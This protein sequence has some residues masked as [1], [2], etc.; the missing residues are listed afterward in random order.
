MYIKKFELLGCAIGIVTVLLLCFWPVTTFDYVWD[1]QFIYS[2]FSGMPMWDAVSHAFT[3]AFLKENYYRPVSFA[4]WLTALNFD[5]SAFILHLINLT[6]HILNSLLIYVIVFR[7]AVNYADSIYRSLIAA[8]AALFYGLSPALAQSVAWVSA[9]FDLQVTFFLLLAVALDGIINSLKLRIIAVALCFLLATLCKEMAATFVIILISLHLLIDKLN[10][11]SLNQE[12]FFREGRLAV[13][14]GILCTGFIYLIIRYANLKYLHV[15]STEDSVAIT[16]KLIISGKILFCYL[17]LIVGPFFNYSPLH[18]IENSVTS[19]DLAAMMGLLFFLV[20]IG[21]LWTKMQDIGLVL[22]AFNFSL[23]PVLNLLG[24][25]GELNPVADRYLTLPLAILT[26]GLALLLS[27]YLIYFNRFKQFVLSI[28]VLTWLSASVFFGRDAINIWRN[29]IAL[30]SYTVTVLPNHSAANA[31]LAAPLLAVN[32]VQLAKSF[33]EKSQQIS[34]NITA[35]LVLGQIALLEHQYHLATQYLLDA[36]QLNTETQDKDKDK[37]N[38][39]LNCYLLF[40]LVS[41]D[42]LDNARGILSQSQL[43]TGCTALFESLYYLS[44]NDL[45]HAQRLFDTGMSTTP[46]RQIMEFAMLVSWTKFKDAALFLP[47]R[48]YCCGTPNSKP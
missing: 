11:R 7:H 12:S 20:P 32:R 31:N 33:A 6:T 34:P 28:C 44:R 41:D 17:K 14:C 4:I 3:H 9:L 1:D 38:A 46:L 19:P 39:Q 48:S 21:L 8:V 18:V 36:Q 22:C 2:K 27:K 35:L 26:I 42:Q 23:L 15:P 29:E 10:N 37:N 47:L 30:W 43:P 5:N 13:Y 40:A 45:Q 16:N 24:T 25:T